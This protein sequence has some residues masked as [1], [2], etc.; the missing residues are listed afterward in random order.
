[1][2]P[3]VEL[4]GHVDVGCQVHSSHNQRQNVEKL[5]RTVLEERGDAWPKR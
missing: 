1:M 4:C 2:I 5:H 3:C